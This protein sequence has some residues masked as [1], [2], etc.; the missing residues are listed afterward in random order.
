LSCR[1]VAVLF[2]ESSTTVQRWMRRF[3]SG[4]LQALRE[5]QRSGRPHLLNEAQRRQVEVDLRMDPL[6]FGFAAR[7]W[8]A[9]V[10][11]EHLRRHYAVDLGV[12]QCQRIFRQLRARGRRGRIK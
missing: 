10:L 9:R 2:G 11:S 4:G 12:R 6:N 8:N 7:L 5:E 1:Q 3:E